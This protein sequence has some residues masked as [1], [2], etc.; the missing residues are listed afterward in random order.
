[1]LNGSDAQ[2]KKD[3]MLET[4]TESYKE[5]KKNDSSRVTQNGV[6]VTELQRNNE[7]EGRRCPRLSL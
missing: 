2:G 1:M 7:L 5:K 3:Q 4:T 6:L